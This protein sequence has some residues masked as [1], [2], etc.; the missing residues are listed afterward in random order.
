MKL[1]TLGSLLAYRHLVRSL[2]RIGSALDQQN[3]LL[4]RLADHL[5]PEMPVSAA[6]EDSV[7]YTNE[8]DILLSLDYIERTRAQTGHTPSDEEVIAYLAD[9]R[10]QALQSRLNERGEMLTRL[11]GQ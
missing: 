5:A 3:R 6:P 9:E 10:T 11:G 2:D 7:S 1:R 8:Q 4:L